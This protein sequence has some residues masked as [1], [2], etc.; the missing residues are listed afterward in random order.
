MNRIDLPHLVWALEKLVDGHVVN[1][2][3]S[4]RTPS[5]TPSSPSSAC[6]TS[7]AARTATDLP[8]Q[9]PPLFGQLSGTMYDGK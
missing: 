4:T 7:R 1:R 9:Q 8:G 5:A 3:R 2:I 6:S